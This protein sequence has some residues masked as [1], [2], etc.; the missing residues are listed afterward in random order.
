MLEMMEA[1]HHV[2]GLRAVRLD[3]EPSTTRSIYLSCFHSVNYLRFGFRS[4]SLTLN[5]TRLSVCLVFT[6]FSSRR[7]RPAIQE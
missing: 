5:K 2:V 7:Q 1:A 4:T 6:Y 3:Q